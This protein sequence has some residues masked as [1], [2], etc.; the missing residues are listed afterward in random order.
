MDR[1]KIKR[2]DWVITVM[3]FIIQVIGI[4]I[5]FSTTYNPKDPQ[6]LSNETIKQIIFV[7]VGLVIYFL[8]ASID[9]SWLEN[10]NVIMLLYLII[11][12][13]LIYVKFFGEVIA[14]TTRW[15]KI[16]FFSIQPSEYAKLVIILLTG[17][18]YSKRK[19]VIF[20]LFSQNKFISKLQQNYPNFF[21]F[22]NS[23]I[24][25]SPILILILIQPA[26]GNTVIT[27]MLFILTVYSLSAHHKL[28]NQ[29]L[30]LTI[31]WSVI[32]A[33]IFNFQIDKKQMLISTKDIADIGYTSIIICFITITILIRFFR[34]N[35]KTFLVSILMVICVVFGSQFVWNNM[36]KDY[37]Q[38]RIL[39][40]LEGPESSSTTSG[41][42]VL[43]SMFATGSGMIFGRGFLNGTQSGL[44]TQAHNDFIFASYAEQFGFVGAVILLTLYAILIIRIIRISEQSRNAFGK[45]ICTA[46]AILLMLH[47]FINIGMN[48][49][50]LPVT[51][52]PLP[53]MSSG[54][55]STLMIM[56]VLSFVQS[57][58]SSKP[59]V[60]FADNLMLTS[61]SR[62]QDF[63][64]KI[65][66]QQ[67][68]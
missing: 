35:I 50:Q 48:I 7:I 12:G 54:G 5:I 60:D 53:L 32:I 49:G 19:N 21:M 1:L 25:I 27:L 9:I 37:Q 18:V 42:Q 43:Q 59:A 34:P 23:L 63:N 65:D 8:I 64:F 20:S 22:V 57:V 28:L 67:D 40:Y 30:A 26:L 41:F 17:F 29:F 66:V 36:L 39:V 13:L 62:M 56:I 47:I 4:A 6:T 33:Q 10:K 11:I 38:D 14:D 61:A 46:T 55:S 44:N 58:N 15:I 52:I 68:E 3:A 2:H 31:I 16:G 24:L 45:N 51:G